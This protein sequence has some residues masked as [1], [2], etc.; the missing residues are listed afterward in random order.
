MLP[1]YYGPSIGH[2]INETSSRIRAFY[3]VYYLVRVGRSAKLSPAADESL[4][5]AVL[6]KM[7]YTPLAT[8]ALCPMP[9]ALC[10][11]EHLM[12]L[13]K[14]ILGILI[15]EYTQEFLTQIYYQFLIF[16]SSAGATTNQKVR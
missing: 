7:R 14:A 10:P 3:P 8:D 11:R 15:A 12:L 2:D 6:N 9:Y 16:P 5:I 13:R 4:Y 1:E